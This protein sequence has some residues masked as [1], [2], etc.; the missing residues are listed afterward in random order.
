MNFALCLFFFIFLLV[1]CFCC[2]GVHP[3]PRSSLGRLLLN[4]PQPP[5]LAT[6]PPLSMDWGLIWSN[7]GPEKDSPRLG[8][9]SG[10]V[11]PQSSR[12]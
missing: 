12:L 4:N 9:P 7:G 1:F 10:V 11:N 8:L 3:Y 5:G 6:R 2:A